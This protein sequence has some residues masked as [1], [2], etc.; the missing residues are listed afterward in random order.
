[1]IRVTSRRNRHLAYLAKLER[2][3]F[4][5][6]EG[7][8]IAEGPRLL[9][10]AR[11]A[12]LKPRLVVLSPGLLNA[13]LS[14]PLNA[15]MAGAQA[16]LE[17]EPGLFAAIAHTGTPQGMLAVL[18]EPAREVEP[19][20]ARQAA[21]LLIIDRVQDPGNV[22][23][24]VRSAHALGAAAVLPTVGAGDLLSPK[25]LRAAAGSAFHIPLARPASAASLAGRLQA[26]AVKI[27][28][29]DPRGEL[30]PWEVDFSGKTAIAIGHE[31][32]GLDTAFPNFTRIRIP[33]PGGAESLNA[34]AA[35][36]ILLWE[37][38]RQRLA[39]QGAACPPG[40]G[41]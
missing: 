18:D 19:V 34:A 29:A 38:C 15:W 22:G 24:L 31:T 39:G 30:L 2:R 37:A 5:E 20:L 11:R 14:P 9:E 16:L 40:E 3:R 27:L 10:E 35:G 36:A 8:V 25:A 12:G 28:G 33:M 17:V 41:R 21:L 13:P 6:S 7:V 23:T 1:M 4:R 26:H 32:A